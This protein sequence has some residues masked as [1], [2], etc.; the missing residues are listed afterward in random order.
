MTNKKIKYQ[1]V[2][3][4]IVELVAE[5]GNDPETL[6]EV[7]VDLE[8]HPAGLSPATVTEAARALKER[9][10]AKVVAYCT[11]PVLSGAAVKNVE[12][13][14]LDEL[15]VTDTIPLWPDAKACPRIRQLSIAGVLSETMR[16]ISIEESVSTLFMD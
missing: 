5:H 4:E 11:H 15:V 7:L 8:T 3:P 14:V 12:N 16:R 1:P 9:G 13:S 6:L 10:A 2:P